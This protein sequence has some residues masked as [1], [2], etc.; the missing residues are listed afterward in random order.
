LLTPLAAAALIGQSVVIVFAVHWA[1]GFWNANVGWDFRSRWRA[2]SA[3]QPMSAAASAFVLQFATRWPS[4]T[5][6]Q[7]AGLSLDSA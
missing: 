5:A 2:T 3:D 7:R 6:R 1:K 4:S